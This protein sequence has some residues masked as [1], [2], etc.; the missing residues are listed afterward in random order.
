M[1]KGLRRQIGV[2]FAAMTNQVTLEG[3]IWPRIARKE[4]RVPAKHD[5]SGQK[6]ALVDSRQFPECE[7]LRKG[8]KEDNYTSNPCN[9][10]LTSW[11]D[12]ITNL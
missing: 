10:W 4:I 11:Q 1:K 6:E 2:V 8:N 5:S 12:K 3:L 7:E 9:G